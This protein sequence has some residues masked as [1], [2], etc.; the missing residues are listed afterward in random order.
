MSVVISSQ[1][2]VNPHSLT[3][4]RK[5]YLPLKHQKLLEDGDYFLYVFFQKTKLKS[6]LQQS[7]FL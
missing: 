5:D 7:M 3:S 6:S 1:S 4:P 2:V